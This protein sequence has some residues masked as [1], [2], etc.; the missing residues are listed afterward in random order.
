M[1]V[2]LNQYIAETGTEHHVFTNEWGDQ[3]SPRTMERAFNK[4]RAKVIADEVEAGVPVRDRLD[5]SFRFHDL[6]HYFASYLISSGVDIKTVQK[7]L[8]HASAK[9]T[10]DVYGHMFPDRD[11]ST[12][13]AVS[14]AFDERPKR[15]VRAV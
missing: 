10:L 7:R 13:D 6:R 3:L 5:A 2:E 4:A 8:R 9:T 14:A 11:D 1:T 12:R 15:V